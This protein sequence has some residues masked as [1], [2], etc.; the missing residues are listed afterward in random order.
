MLSNNFTAARD[1]ARRAAQRLPAFPNALK[2]LPFGFLRAKR[3]LQLRRREIAVVGDQLFTDVLGGKLCGLYTILTEPIERKDLA[4]TQILPV[5]RAA[6]AARAARVK[7]ALIGDP[8]EHSA[9]P[10]LHRGFLEEADIDG[11]YVAIRVPRGEARRRSARLRSD[12]YTGC[13]VTYPLKEEAAIAC[14][15][16]TDEARARRSRQYDFLRQPNRRHEYRRHRRPHAPSKRCSTS[17]S[18]SNASASWATARPLARF[19]PSCTTTMRTR[20]YGG[21]TRSARAKRAGASKR[22]LWPNANPPEIVV[23]TLPPEALLPEDLVGALQSPDVVMDANYGRSLDARAF[24]SPRRRAGRRDARGASA[25]QLRLLASPSRPRRRRLSA[26]CPDGGEGGIRTLER[27][28]TSARFPSEYIQ[29]LC[30][31]SKMEILGGSHRALSCGT[32]RRAPRRRC[33][34]RRRTRSGTP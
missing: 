34:P 11:S 3:C 6:D 26:R 15:V 28:I 18:R 22:E 25:C 13:N 14:D 33:G 7:L 29:P 16:L 12:G 4:V 8:V 5:L 17:R 27:L 31:L 30:H 10:R 2:P 19:L 21:A 23:S 1:G 20:S 32:L 9:S 24:A